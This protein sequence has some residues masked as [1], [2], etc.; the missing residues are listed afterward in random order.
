MGCY[1]VYKDHQLFAP[2]VKIPPRQDTETA[3]SS[4][5][6]GKKEISINR[7][8]VALRL[9]EF[10]GDVQLRALYSLTPV[11]MGSLVV[12]EGIESR[13]KC[14]VHILKRLGG[15]E[16]KELVEKLRNLNHPNILRVNDAVKNLGTVCLVYE[17]CE[18][19]SAMEMVKKS[20]PIPDILSLCII[21]QV[22]SGIRHC[23]AADFLLRNLSLSHVLFIEPPS[24]SN[25]HIKLLPYDDRKT[26]TIAPEATEPNSALPAS[27]VYSAGLILAQML[28]GDANPQSA[29]SRCLRN[30]TRDWGHIPLAAKEFI[31][32]L[33]SAD[34]THRPSIDQCFRHSWIASWQNP[35]SE[36][37]ESAAVNAIRSL[38]SGKPM[39][40]LKQALLLFVFNQTY[41]EAQMKEVL[42]A[43]RMLDVDMDGQV[44]GSEI[45]AL[46]LKHYSKPSARGYFSAILKATGMAAS[47][48]ISFSEFLIRGCNRS[49]LMSHLALTPVFHMLDREHRG[50]VSLDRVKEVVRIEE[51]MDSDREKTVWTRAM[52][53]V[54]SA[55]E[56]I[57]F[58]DFCVYLRGTKSTNT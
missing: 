2:G 8:E 34:V 24:P 18:G 58:N 19:Q 25:V 51:Q 52:A 16:A 33:I 47:G 56:G 44:S 32:S 31:F 27:D 53:E 13:K 37:A 45:L 46:L 11:V 30:S 54:T 15:T 29:L 38:A 10:H 14:F 43:F 57:S 48:S 17:N 49:L 35:P 41:P 20:G 42:L 1:C 9:R 36:V 12:A 50:R 40:Q 28:L 6:A 5:A 55:S 26:E 39:P 3:G 23:H 7:K 21:K 22:L 4:Q